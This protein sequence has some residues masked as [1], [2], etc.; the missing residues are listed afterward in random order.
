MTG[1]TLKTCIIFICIFLFAVGCDQ[2]T[3][4]K[5][6]VFI[7]PPL[8]REKKTVITKEGAEVLS[9]KTEKKAVPQL[10][11]FIHGPKAQN[12]CYLCH[13][14]SDSYSFRKSDTKGI[15]MPSLSD[16]AGRLV[17]P[18]SVLCLDCHTSKSQEAAYSKKL[19][20][21]GPVAQG[22]CTLCHQPH[23][24]EYQYLMLKKNSIE[25]CT[26]C[27]A[28]RLLRE[29]ESHRTNDECISC[30]NPHAGKD[31]LLLKKDHSEQF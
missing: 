23:Q 22:E 18:L 21:H 25:L 5:I 6:L 3:K 11:H 4:R 29:I 7:F 2:Y 24:S 31:S 26:E 20:L 17:M 16:V 10:A 8:G 1:N 15:V 19:W 30:H 12:Q 14:S 9:Q 13:E 28:K 27:H